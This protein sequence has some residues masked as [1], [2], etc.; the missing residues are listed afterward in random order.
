M[1][2]GL[3][4]AL[5]VSG[6]KL[7][8]KCAKALEAVVLDAN[9]TFWSQRA[10]KHCTLKVQ[11]ELQNCCS[12]GVIPLLNKQQLVANP[13]YGGWATLYR[14]PLEFQ[15]RWTANPTPVPTPQPTHERVAA[16]T[17]SPTM[18]MMGQAASSD[19]ITEVVTLPPS[20]VPTAFENIKPPPLQADIKLLA[21][22]AAPL[23]FAMQAE[24]GVDLSG[25]GD[26]PADTGEKK[27]SGGCSVDCT[28]APRQQVCNKYLGKAC[29]LKHYPLPNFEVMNSLYRLSD[30]GEAG[31]TAKMLKNLEKFVVTEDF[32]VPD[33][34][35][36]VPDLEAIT[37][38]YFSQQREFSHEYMSIACDDGS[39][40]TISLAIG[41]V[42]I[43]AFFGAIFYVLIVPPKMPREYKVRRPDKTLG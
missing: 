11:N 24:G 33:E 5:L 34:C 42:V 9:L 17:P 1:R 27:C 30:D 10:T 39:M 40:G 14:V 8:E 26:K 25:S 37:F 29:V 6:A 36:N 15:E 13:R 43:F 41:L 22:P 12:S 35:N 18:A 16:P 7:Q 28:M 19:L 4:L 23:L 20:P 32:C 2:W 3:V 31:K 21:A 38:A